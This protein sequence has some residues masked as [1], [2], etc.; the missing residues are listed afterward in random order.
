MANELLREVREFLE[1]SGIGPWYFGSAACGNSSLVKRLEEGGTVTLETAEKIRTFIADWRRE[2][3][4][5]AA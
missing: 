5:H 4:E 1:E 2:K 3:A